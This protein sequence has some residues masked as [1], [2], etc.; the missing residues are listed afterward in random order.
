MPREVPV[1]VVT[2][3]GLLTQIDAL[4]AIL[5]RLR[6]AERPMISLNYCT[7]SPTQSRPNLPAKAKHFAS[8]GGAVQSVLNLTERLSCPPVLPPPR[9][10]CL[11]IPLLPCS[12]RK[13]SRALKSP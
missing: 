10:P 1:M 5:S 6:D 7:S 12:C 11:L 2:L 4:P 8:S 9:R 13:A 3:P